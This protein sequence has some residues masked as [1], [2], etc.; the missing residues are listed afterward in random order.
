[1]GDVPPELEDR[2]RA[3]GVAGLA[4]GFPFYRLS[5]GNNVVGLVLTTGTDWVEVAELLT[6]SYRVQAP[7]KLARLLD[8][9]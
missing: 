7:K 4:A 2:L 3:D 1:M 9:R 5:W 8:G 6:D